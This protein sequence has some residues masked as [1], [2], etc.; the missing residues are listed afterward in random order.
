MG[1]ADMKTNET[2]THV[3]KY[4]RHKEGYPGGESLP[5]NPVI[6]SHTKVQSALS[7]K[8]AFFYVTV[9]DSYIFRLMIFYNVGSMETQLYISIQNFI[10]LE[11][12]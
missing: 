4:A 11:Q 12:E 1:H 3:I 6:Y 10:V 2:F 8:F 9:N 5:G 7:I